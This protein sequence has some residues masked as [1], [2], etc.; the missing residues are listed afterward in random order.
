MTIIKH[1]KLHN[2]APHHVVVSGY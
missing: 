2:Y 1:T